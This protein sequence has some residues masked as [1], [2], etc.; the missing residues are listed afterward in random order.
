MPDSSI[1][2]KV[3]D[4]YSNNL[5][6]I[7][8]AN[9]G[10][11]KSME[12][13]QRA[14]SDM[15]K[16]LSDNQKQLAAQKVELEK[17]KKAASEAKKE[18]EK[19]L[20]PETQEA[21]TAATERVETLN[22]E[23]RTL[24]AQC[25]SSEKQLLSLAETARRISEVPAVG[26]RSSGAGDGLTKLINNQTVMG[27]AKMGQQLVSEAVDVFGS[28]AFGDATAS[29]MSSGLSGAISGAAMGSVAGPIGTV[30]GGAV[31]AA[32]GLISAGI[33]EAGKKDDYF[34]SNVQEAYNDIHE[35][36]DEQVETGSSTFGGRETLLL[37]YKTLMD[38]NAE[39]AQEL[40]DELLD[41]ANRTPY[42]LGQLSGAGRTLL[43][44]G[45]EGTDI[46]SVLGAI[47]SAAA[48]T[49]AGAQG[50]ETMAQVIGR[51]NTGEIS[52]RLLRSLNSLG[53]NSYQT[54][55]D[56]YNEENGTSY[57]SAEMK[58]LVSKGKIT[59]EWAAQALLE[60][61][62]TNWG[63][64]MEAFSKTYEGLMSTLTGLEE[65]RQAFVGERYNETR[66]DD[67]QGE[68]YYRNS[69][70]GQT[71][72]EIEGYYG[73]IQGK[74]DNAQ[75]R[76]RREVERS[77]IDGTI[78][79]ELGDDVND[80]LQGLHQQYVEYNKALEQAERDKDAAGV[81]AAKLAIAGLLDSAREYADTAWKNSDLFALIQGKELDLID[82]LQDATYQSWYDYGYM[83]ADALSKGAAGAAMANGVKED[84]PDATA[85]KPRSS[86]P[87]SR[88]NYDGS[89]AY[90]L[91]RVPYNGYIAELHEGERVLTASEARQQDAGASGITVNVNVSG[92]T[93]RSDDD[94]TAIAEAVAEQLSDTLRTYVR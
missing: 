9:K 5:K 65:N 77:L 76:Y 4:Q 10:L 72:T 75:A 63:S 43:A 46:Q 29:Y 32:T 1:I 18:Y 57:G 2:I 61:W 23:V 69:E 68:I 16:K 36:R 55:A 15:S 42:T 82:N 59:G 92:A 13:V 91:D 22:G 24:G 47:G 48:A 84:L 27:F 26:G 56:Q 85:V 54:L 30:I 28:Q 45:Y 7:A 78:F 3:I 38:G 34:K 90:G 6:N 53:M 93:V 52:A 20:T 58:E 51:M 33:K 88:Y 60:Q 80:E 87:R 19:M 35:Y 41:Y 50:L 40:Y 49:G 70:I 83:I 86:N 67:I 64:A 25:K 74:A 44:Y 62:G 89:N 21:W 8:S 81:D 12:E 39:A 11:N 71:V 94:I 79:D 14:A 73:D 17:A 31:G 37:S 66:K